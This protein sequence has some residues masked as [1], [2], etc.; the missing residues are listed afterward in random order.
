[1]LVERYKLLM[2]KVCMLN[3]GKGA[4]LQWRSGI[5]VWR[6]L[7]F[8]ERYK[9]LM[10]KVCMLNFGKGVLLQWRSGIVVWRVLTVCNSRITP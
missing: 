4:L 3:F 8:V 1:M 10:P 9:L 6:V 2:P 7:T 5:I